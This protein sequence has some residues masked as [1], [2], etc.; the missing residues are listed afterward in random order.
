MGLVA[1]KA[2]PL[3][4]QQSLITSQLRSLF[5]M[6][7]CLYKGHE[8]SNIYSRLKALVLIKQRLLNSGTDYNRCTLS[9]PYD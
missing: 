3:R 9:K 2:V 7:K 1:R 6:A 8:E 5:H 4:T